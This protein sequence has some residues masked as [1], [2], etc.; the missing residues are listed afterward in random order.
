MHLVLGSFG[1]V[2]TPVHDPSSLS[3]PRPLDP[4]R[5]SPV[6]FARS[7]RNPSANADVL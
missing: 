3:L 4:G 6:V 1:G 7:G 5:R 2:L